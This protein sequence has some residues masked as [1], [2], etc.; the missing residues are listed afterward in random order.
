MMSKSTPFRTD[1]N[2]REI[3]NK[4]LLALSTEAFDL[5]RPYLEFTE[6][7]LRFELRRP[8]EPAQFAY[9]LN[10]GVASLIIEMGEGKTAEVSVVGR[11]GMAGASFAVGLRRSPLREMIQLDGSGFR[12]GFAKLQDVLERSSELQRVLGRYAVFQGMEIAQIAGCNRLHD[13]EQR[14]ARWLL[15]VQDR[16][17]VDSIPATQDFLSILLGITRPNVS[18]IASRLQRKGAIKYARGQIRIVNR[19]RLEAASCECYRILSNWIVD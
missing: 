4:L 9:F 10:Q 19:K 6:L 5:A 12:V 1:V 16:G 17:S 15:M 7:P 2:G 13:S 11:E 14:L 3:C 8:E 18:A